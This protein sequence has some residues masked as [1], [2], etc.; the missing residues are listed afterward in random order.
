MGGKVRRNHYMR[1]FDWYHDGT[2]HVQVR[3]LMAL[4]EL[5]DD[6]TAQFKIIRVTKWGALVQFDFR[7]TIESIMAMADMGMQLHGKAL[8]DP[9]YAG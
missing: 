9:E 7:F 2:Y 6:K 3:R 8:E 5:E 4:R 1:V